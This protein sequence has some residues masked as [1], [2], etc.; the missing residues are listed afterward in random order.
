M[1][2]SKA[3]ASDFCF[4]VA[5][6]ALELRTKHTCLKMASIK[7]PGWVGVGRKWGLLLLS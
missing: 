2:Y 6:A 7:D 5:A 4:F 3:L 1:Q